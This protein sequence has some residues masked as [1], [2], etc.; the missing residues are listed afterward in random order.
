MTDAL[1]DAELLATAIVQGLGSRPL[2]AALQDYGQRRDEA[3]RPMH[4]L[5]ADF[6]RLAPPPP[7]MAALL[8][9]LRDNPAD[10]A[11]FLGVI[12]R[13]VP[14]ADFFAPA[15]LARITGTDLAA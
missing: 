13:T 7:A 2:D 6:A 3:A 1:L 15:N 8:E 11:R 9:A 10:T 5:T 14:A 4:E 12:A